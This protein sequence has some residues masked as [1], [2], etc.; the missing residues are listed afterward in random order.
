MIKQT[1]LLL[2]AFTCMAAA[3]QLD[4]LPSDKDL[5]KKYIEELREGGAIV[6]RLK[7]RVKAIAAYRSSGENAIA[8]RMQEEDQ[9]LNKKIVEAFTGEFRFCP[10]YFTYANTSRALLS[11]NTSHLLNRDLT[12]DSTISSKHTNFLFVDYGTSML[13]ES[14]NSYNYTYGNTTEGSTPGNSQAYV[15]LDKEF[16][17]LHAPFPYVVYLNPFE[18]NAHGKAIARLN[19][20]LFAYYA[21][22]QKKKVQ[23]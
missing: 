18:H 2:F 1:L 13:N 15:V 8:N 3:A 12:P 21:F 10:V 20:K 17:Q 5:A 16:M 7:A 14:T 9:K 6:V 19:K 4:S 11:G 22:I 23:K